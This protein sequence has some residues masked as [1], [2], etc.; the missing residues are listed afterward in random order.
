MNTTLKRQNPARDKS[1][2]D[3]IC[4]WLVILLEP[5]DVI[6]DPV[7]LLVGLLGIV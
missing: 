1:A 3:V 5:H 2:H 4:R 6:K 7:G